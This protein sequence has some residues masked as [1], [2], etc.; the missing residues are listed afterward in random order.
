MDDQTAGEVRVGEHYLIAVI[1]EYVLVELREEDRHCKEY[2]EQLL[3]RVE[4]RFSINESKFCKIVY[5]IFFYN[6]YDHLVGSFKEWLKVEVLKIREKVGTDRVIS[7]LPGRQFVKSPVDCET[8][9]DKSKSF[10]ETSMFETQL[11][12]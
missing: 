8:T 1:S 7:E 9:Y 12:W 2:L 11:S 5:K 3:V 4:K 6:D 10:V